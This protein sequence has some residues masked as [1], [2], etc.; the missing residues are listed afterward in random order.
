VVGKT[1]AEKGESLGEEDLHL[2]TYHIPDGKY[3]DHGAIFL[4][5]GQRPKEVNS[6]AVGKDGSVYALAAITQ[7][8]HNRTDLMRIPTLMGAR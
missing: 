2:I 7:N 1:E 4:P 8:G 5:D 3:I 6:I